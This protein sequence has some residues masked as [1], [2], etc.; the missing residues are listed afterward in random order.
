[1]V[2]MA[3]GPGHP[4]KIRYRGPKMKRRL[5]NE[6]YLPKHFSFVRL[7]LGFLGPRQNVEPT[8]I[9]KGSFSSTQKGRTP[10]NEVDEE[11]QKSA[12]A[13]TEVVEEVRLEE[14]TICRPAL[15][16]SAGPW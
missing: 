10:A 15:D 6:R 14:A 4:P 1:M 12:P 13:K 5:S 16:A 7:H 11:V 2:T 8:G 3:H 9:A